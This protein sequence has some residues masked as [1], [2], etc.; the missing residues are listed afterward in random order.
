MKPIKIHKRDEIAQCRLPQ[1]MRTNLVMM[2]HRYKIKKEYIY[3]K[4]DHQ[5][6]YS[7]AVRINKDTLSQ[8]LKQV[9]RRAARRTIQNAYS[10]MY[11]IGE[12]IP[13]PKVFAHEAT[14]RGLAQSY[15][16]T[17]KKTKSKMY[18]Y[19]MILGKGDLVDGY[20]IFME[21]CHELILWVND[22]F[23]EFGSFPKA[24]KHIA[25]NLLHGK[26]VALY[27]AMERASI[28]IDKPTIKFNT[29]KTLIRLKRKYDKEKK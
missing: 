25:P 10:I 18:R 15:F 9:K 12:F 21:K 29:F 11:G 20:D 28:V 14:K 13:P 24:A 5:K 27:Y 19:L 3:Y 6:N 7:K 1:E 8:L 26:Y 2:I 23:F 4:S 17:L 22:L 16:A